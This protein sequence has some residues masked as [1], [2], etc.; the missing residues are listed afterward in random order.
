MSSD[1]P[2]QD[3]SLDEEV[4]ISNSSN[5]VLP[6]GEALNTPK[7]ELGL[8][9]EVA[10]TPVVEAARPQAPA[11]ELELAWQSFNQHKKT[12]RISSLAALKNSPGF[13]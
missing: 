8:D 10:S 3:F 12:V 7:L 2:L 13:K 6:L 5:K 4:G 1:L 9:V 11:L